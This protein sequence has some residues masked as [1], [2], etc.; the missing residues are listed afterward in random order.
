M[1]LKEGTNKGA[2]QGLSV[3]PLADTF[4]NLVPLFLEGTPKKG[5]L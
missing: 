5:S 2:M 3:R 4:P 1:G